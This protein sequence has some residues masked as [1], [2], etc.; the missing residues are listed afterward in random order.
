MIFRRRKDSP[1]KQLIASMYKL[2]NAL[3]RIEMFI[4]RIDSRRKKM[5]EIVT[6]LEMKGQ[7]ELAKRYSIEITKLDAIKSRLY[8]LHLVLEKVYLSLEYALTLRNFS[9]IAREVLGITDKIKKLPESTIPDIN[10][11]LIDLE[12]SLRSI[13]GGES[14]V[15]AVEYTPASN[16]EV[17]KILEEA[18]MVIRERLMVDNE[19]ASSRSKL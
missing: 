9:G 11:A 19:G 12:Y 18:R 15:D 10:M 6:E 14:M 2:K 1:Y 4:D 3:N 8:A 5:F 16:S 17:E 13:E 7:H